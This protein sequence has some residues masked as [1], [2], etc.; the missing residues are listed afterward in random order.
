MIDERSERIAANG[1]RSFKEGQGLIESYKAV[2]EKLST[3]SKSHK[4]ASKEISRLQKNL[5]NMTD[6]ELQ[7]LE[8]TEPAHDLKAT[9]NMWLIN[10]LKLMVKR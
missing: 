10:I 7:L 2:K 8:L 3:L 9:M 6:E 5:E 1:E 4:I